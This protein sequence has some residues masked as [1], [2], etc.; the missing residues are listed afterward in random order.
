MINRAISVVLSVTH[1]GTPE[2]YVWSGKN[3]ISILYNFENW[4][5][6]IVV[7]LQQW[8]AAVKHI[9]IIRIKHL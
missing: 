4:L 1:N 3:Y 7:S 2:R 8:L 5:F 9:G 6:S